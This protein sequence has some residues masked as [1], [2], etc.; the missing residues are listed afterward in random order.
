M[1]RHDRIWLWQR[2]F[3]NHAVILKIADRL[4][5][6]VVDKAPFDIVGSTRVCMDARVACFSLM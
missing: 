1:H 2:L 4:L 3:E 5:V 6:G